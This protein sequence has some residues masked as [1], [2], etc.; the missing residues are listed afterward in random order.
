MEMLHSSRK[1][2]HEGMS[3]RS[4]ECAKNTLEKSCSFEIETDTY[5]LLHGYVSAVLNKLVLIIVVVL[6]HRL[7]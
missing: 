3:W 7:P 1:K 4:D 5:N 2:Q 6:L